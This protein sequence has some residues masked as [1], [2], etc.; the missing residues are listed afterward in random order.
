MNGNIIFPMPLGMQDLRS[1]PGIEPGPPAGKQ[2]QGPNKWGCSYLSDS[3]PR[4]RNYFFADNTVK[5]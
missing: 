5:G 4:V 2:A 3:I 1:S